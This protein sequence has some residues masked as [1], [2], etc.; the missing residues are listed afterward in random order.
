MR[1]GGGTTFGCRHYV[2]DS[3]PRMIGAPCRLC[4]AELDFASTLLDLGI[5]HRAGNI[6]K[7]LRE[8]RVAYAPRLAE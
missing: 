7:T 1:Q 5:R 8:L 3:T 6:E 4:F 2:A